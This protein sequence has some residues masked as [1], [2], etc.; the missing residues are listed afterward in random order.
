MSKDK[1]VTASIKKEGLKFEILVHAEEAHAY[2][3][4]GSVSINDVIVAEEVFAD[5]KKGERASEHEMERLFGTK[6]FLKVAEIILKEGHIPRTEE[7][8]KQEAEDTKKQ[9]IT[10]VVRNVVDPNTGKPH[11]PGRIETAIAEA[12]VRID[13]NKS[14]EE[15]LQD[16]VKALRPLLPI[17]FETR[18]ILIKIPVQHAGRCQP[19]LKQMTRVVNE[20]WEQDGSLTATIEVPAGVQEELELHLNKI[21]RGDMELKIIGAK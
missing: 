14:A 6:D 7:M 3:K 20:K 2:A 8:L 17:K 10:L 15:Q 21:T 16:V 11:P 4:G 13:A 12:K 18:E 9:I 1:Q 19:I 5:V